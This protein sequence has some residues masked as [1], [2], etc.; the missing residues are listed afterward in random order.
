MSDHICR[1]DAFCKGRSRTEDGKGWI[2]AATT[3]SDTL[4]ESCIR[5]V[6]AAVRELWGDYMALSRMI[7]EKPNTT[8]S[9]GG[10]AAPAS[11]V[12]INVHVDALMGDI[13]QTVDRCAE[14]VADAMRI[15]NPEQKLR[16]ALLAAGL[17]IIEPNI[18]V[19]AQ[20]G[21]FDAVEWE[22]G[23]EKFDVIELNG[24]TLCL[25]LADLHRRARSQAGETRG[26]DKM[27]VPC[28][29]C[30]YTALGRW[31]GAESVDCARCGS[32]WSDEDYKRLTMVL[33][34][35]YKELIR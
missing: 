30:E 33:A 21:K 10:K 8:R 1:A 15:P 5:H 29:R 2:P 19:L 20:V 22:P 34:D 17:A 25:Q 11:Q 13:V 7:G 23:G 28:P 16:T 32:V 31:H 12:P 14:Q 24:P 26:R 3:V 9:E 35:D 18:A 27:P 4:C 6:E